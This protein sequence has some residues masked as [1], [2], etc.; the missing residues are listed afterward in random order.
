MP[1]MA[2]R[3]IAAIAKDPAVDIVVYVFE[4]PE[5]DRDA[6]PF[7]TAMLE[8]V[9]I[10]AKTAAKPVVVMSHQVKNVSQSGDE[11]IER[12]DLPYMSGGLQ[13]GMAALANVASWWQSLRSVEQ[14]EAAAKSEAGR[15]LASNYDTEFSAQ[16]LL[17]RFEVG[18]VPTSLV[19]SA[20][21]AADAAAEF[22]DLLVLKIS[23]PDIAHKTE[24]GGVRIGVTV[25]DAA[26]EF[27]KLVAAV[28]SAKPHAR[29]DGVLV[30][31]MRQ[32]ALELI[33]GV[34]RDPQW[35]LVLAV[36]F[37]GV[38]VELLKDVS[39]RLLPATSREIKQMLSELSAARLLQ[40]Y[41]GS[42]PADIDLLAETIRRIGE[43]AM[44]VADLDTLEVNPL[45]VCGSQIE[46]L[47][48][49]VVGTGVGQ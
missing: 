18:V 35:G 45:R 43:A 5:D 36:G 30:S 40:G 15:E 13:Y 6:A 19:K 20:K 22:D 17:R 42:P 24:V 26:A 9:A 27:D 31:P 23:S 46:A 38:L 11:L 32:A 7:S 1:D 48:A 34:V 39:M 4:V 21:E 14:I 2:G 33:V 37:G 49:L 12:L 8:S 3:A 41:R 10:A 16:Q 28:Q 47:D 25:Q 44:S 29:I